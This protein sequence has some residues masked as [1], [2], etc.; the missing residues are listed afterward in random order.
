MGH[1]SISNTV[2]YLAVADRRVRNMGALIPGGAPSRRSTNR[3][4]ATRIRERRE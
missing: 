1:R 3:E 2:I 4:R